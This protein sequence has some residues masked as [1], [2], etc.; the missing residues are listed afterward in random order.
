MRAGWTMIELIF[1]LIVIGIL[2][3]I[4]IERLAA[5]R[6]DAK[7]S[8]TVHNM[9]VCISDVSAH[10]VAT[11]IDYNATDHPTSCS[12]ANTKC[13]NI[14]WGGSSGDLNITTRPDADVYCL[15]IEIVGGH[16]AKSYYF[17]G[18]RIKK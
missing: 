2:A 5:T 18:S 1:I 4:A 12:E 9:G 13:Y 8:T 17:G 7:L 3:A 6:D 16:L 10:Y 14:D 11:G 15:D